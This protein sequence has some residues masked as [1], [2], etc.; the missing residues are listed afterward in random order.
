MKNTRLILI[1]A[2]LA[3]ALGPALALAGPD[4]DVGFRGWGP[5]V[6]LSLD[7]DQVHFGAHLDFG[8]FAEHV[9][10]QPNVEL[11]FG[12]DWKIY[13]VNAEAAYRFRSS[14]DVWTPYLGG[15]LGA[16]IK[17]FDNGEHNNSETDLGVNLL[18]GIEKGL[19]NGDRFFIEAKF[20]LND[21]DM[22]NAKITIGWTF[23]H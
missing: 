10:F 15:G 18:G 2:A 20:S 19:A 9:R 6:G 23:Y 16:N 21:N 1:A 14:W 22:P 4:T 12:D 8:N 13:T 7:P 5:R 17:S 11:G 3:V